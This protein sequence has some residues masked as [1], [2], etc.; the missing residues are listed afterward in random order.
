MHG[1][2]PIA[3]WPRGCPGSGT[4]ARCRAAMEQY[5]AMITKLGDVRVGAVARAMWERLP[6]AERPAAYAEAQ[7]AAVEIGTLSGTFGE[8]FMTESEEAKAIRFIDEHPSQAAE[9]VSALQTEDPKY[10]FVSC[11]AALGTLQ[12]RYCW[13]CQRDYDDG[14]G[15]ALGRSGGVRLRL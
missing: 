1:N 8:C 15:S 4:V 14:G 10:P 5:R 9:V 3:A 11:N 13:A 6:K 12:V 2:R 7:F